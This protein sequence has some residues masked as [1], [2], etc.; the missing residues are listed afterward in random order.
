MA[1]T[2]DTA[3]ALPVDVSNAVATFG[4]QYGF[5]ERPTH[6]NTLQ[7]QAKFEVFGHG[8]ADLSETG[9]GVTLASAYKYGYSVEENTM[10]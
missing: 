10:R 7:E 9:Y 8:W 5:I 6:R 2:P 3:V 1:H 4:T